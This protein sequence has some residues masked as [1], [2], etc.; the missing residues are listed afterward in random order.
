MPLFGTIDNDRAMQMHERLLETV[1]RTR[2]RVAILD[3]TGVGNID[4]HTADNI[5]RLVHSVQLL[6]ARGIIVGIRP[7]VAQSI[8][9]LGVD[10]SRIRTLSNLREALL[11][12]MQGWRLPGPRA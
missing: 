5:I 3:L 6:G 1:V 12:C 7:D 2:A 4:T 10:L 11:L 8:V 9:A